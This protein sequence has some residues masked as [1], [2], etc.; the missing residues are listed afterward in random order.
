[1]GDRAAMFPDH[2]DEDWLNTPGRVHGFPQE[3]STSSL[4]SLSMG[5]VLH[6]ESFP[7][8]YREIVRDRK[9][10]HTIVV[11]SVSHDKVPILELDSQCTSACEREPARVGVKHADG[12]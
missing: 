6:G 9:H 2:H 7:A 12:P 11:P 10:W 1:M 4:L 3:V 8:P 5:H